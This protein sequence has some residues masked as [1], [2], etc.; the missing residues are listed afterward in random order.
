[1]PTNGEDPLDI[2]DRA[3][4]TCQRDAQTQ[5]MV[6][7]YWNTHALGVGRCFQRVLS[8]NASLVLRL[9]EAYD[10]LNGGTSVSQVLHG[11]LDVAVKALFAVEGVPPLSSVHDVRSRA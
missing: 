3:R 4:V 6:R 11:C 9:K 5:S 8:E 2:V 7:G 10:E 1:M